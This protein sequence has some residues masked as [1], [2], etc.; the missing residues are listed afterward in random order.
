MRTLEF[1]FDFASHYSY[2]S[3]MRIEALAAQSGVSIAWRPFLLGPIFKAQG[4]DTSPFAIYPVKG[5]Y[6]R[7]DVERLA[8]S[9]GLTFKE[10]KPFPQ[11]SMKAARIAVVGQT[12]G[13]SALFA[14]SVFLAEFRDLKPIDDENVL[15]SLLEAHGLQSARIVTEAET[16]DNKLRLRKQTEEAVAKGIFGAPTFVTH[17]GEVFWGDDRLEQAIAWTLGH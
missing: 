3:A 10:P 17:D 15:K 4:W 11:N 6:A 14:K 12:E 2:L 13:W 16:S 5:A 9:R 8:V 1:W 7:R